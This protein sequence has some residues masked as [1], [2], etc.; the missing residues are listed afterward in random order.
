MCVSQ[1]GLLNQSWS[2]FILGEVSNRFLMVDD[3]I[4]AIIIPDDGGNSRLLFCEHML[5]KLTDCFVPV[6]D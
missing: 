6:R 1:N 2:S 5:T 4:L 3:A